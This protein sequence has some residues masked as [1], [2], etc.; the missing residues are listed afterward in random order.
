MCGLTFLQ[1]NSVDP[2]T[3]RRATRRALKAMGHRGP[4]E[5]GITELPGVVCGHRRLSIIDLTGSRQPMQD[6]SG[7]FTLVYN[8]EIYNYQAQRNHLSGQW[9]FRTHGDSE[10]LL[11]GL[12]LEGT[13]FLQGLNGMWAFALWDQH[14]NTLL[15]GRDRMGKK[16]LYYRRTA[17][18]FSVASEIPALQHLDPAPLSE[19]VDSTADYFRYG[20]YLP[21]TTAYRDVFE[22]PPG[23]VA[24]WRPGR[25]LE[26]FP[27]WQL[28]VGGYNGSKSEA[29]EQLAGVLTAA[30]ERR[31][32]ADVEVGA[33]LSGGI[34][35]SLIVA[36]LTRN[37]E[38]RPRTF[39]IGFREASYDERDYARTVAT[40]C[41]TRHVEEVLED[42]NERSLESLLAHHIGQPFADASLLPTAL[43][44]RVASR[45]VKVA[46]SGD[47][48]DELFSGYQRYQARAILMWY[49]RLP[50]TARTGIEYLIRKIPEPMAHHSRSIV[51]KAH[52][53][54]DVAQRIEGET[55]YIAPLYYSPENLE[56]LIPELSGSGHRPPMLPEE[57]EPD[58][59][60]RMM[61]AD[62][63]VYLPQDIMTKVDRASMAHSLETRAPFLDVEV[64]NLAFSFPRRWHRRGINGK[65]M[66]RS[67]FPGLLPDQIWRRRKQGFGVPIHEWFRGDLGSRLEQLLRNVDSPLSSDFVLDRLREH[68]NR[69]R[70]HGYRLWQIFAYLVWRTGARN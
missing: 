68:R 17:A 32:V 59:L 58:D 57:T 6:A 10:V 25:T 2:E 7:R 70:D 40:Q 30:V 22:V 41:D 27:Y 66:L 4:D 3:L 51:K 62:A 16:P 45:Y 63:L 8:G 47:G 44:S 37:L 9:A 19:D 5:E 43:V 18:R 48:G 50:K 53:F 64:V 26:T 14:R 65:R 69:S 39:T 15:L 61:T 42:W 12:V 35:S 31:L 56:R 1:D 54:A 13:S 20:Y 28:S 60:H 33:F 11:A 49:T 55:P 29:S 23:C 36:I 46:L 38:N 67:A 21:G 34:D 52:L 24:T